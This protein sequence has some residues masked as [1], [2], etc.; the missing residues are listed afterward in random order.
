LPSKKEV[1][2]SLLERSSVYV[3]LDPRQQAGIVPPWFKKQPQLVLQIGLNMPVRIPDLRL[4]DEAISCTL[5]FND[6]P[7]FCVV[8]WS[9]IFAMVGENGRGMVWSDDVPVEVARQAQERSKPTPPP[10]ERKVEAVAEP[11]RSNVVL[12]ASGGD[13]YRTM[14]S[15][16]I[17]APRGLLVRLRAFL[18]RS[19]G[20]FRQLRRLKLKLGT[21]DDPPE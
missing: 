14:I 20:W 15:P 2:L 17:E 19:F 8:P 6:M 11:E 12:H 16:P 4:D 21:G 3:H 9:S 10:R 1:A 13:P 18:G 7:F 5:S